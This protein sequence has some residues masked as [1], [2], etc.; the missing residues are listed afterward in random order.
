MRQFYHI[1]LFSIVI[2]WL[3]HH[4]T[5]DH[6]GWPGMPNTGYSRRFVVILKGILGMNWDLPADI[7]DSTADRPTLYHRYR[8]LQESHHCTKR[9]LHVALFARY[10]LQVINYNMADRYCLLGQETCLSLEPEIDFVT[11]PMTM[12]EPCMTWVRQYAIQPSLNDI[13]NKV[14]YP[15]KELPHNNIV[16]A[17]AV[18]VSAKIPGKYHANKGHFALDG[19]V[20]EFSAGNYEILTIS[21][22]WNMSWIRYD[23]SSGNPLPVGAVIG[24]Y[25]DGHLLYV[26]RKWDT[27]AGHSSRYAAGYYDNV[28]REGKVVY[29][30]SVFTFRAMEI[31]VVHEWMKKLHQ[32]QQIY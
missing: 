10:I 12:Q 19:E 3:P 25:R 26:A 8:S 9:T 1:N 22:R 20:S 13:D 27:H 31:L 14:T 16:I 18:L 5:K 17:R 7:H 15:V 6:A 32:K 28:D 21:P 4:A 24:G 29:G 11:I 23:S 30:L 2:L